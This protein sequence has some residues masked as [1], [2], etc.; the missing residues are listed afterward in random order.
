MHSVQYIVNRNLD[1]QTRVRLKELGPPRPELKITQ[2][3]KQSKN[4]TSFTRN[5]NRAMY[6]AADWLCGCEV[7]NAFF[8]FTCLIMKTNDIGWT[9]TGVTDLKNFHAK[10]KK[11][12][13][14][15]THINGGIE[16]AMLGKVDVRC[17]LD[18]AY[19][20]KIKT[21]NED[22]SKNRYILGKLID[23]I[24][25]C[26]KFELALRGH[27]EGEDSNNPGI[28]R[29]LVN[30]MSEL[31]GLLKQHIEKTENRA[32]VGLSKTVQNELLDSIYEVCLNL[33]R[34]E[35]LQTNYIAIEVDETT[36]CATLSQLG[37]I[38]RYELRGKLIERFVSFLQ[39]K[40]D[41]AKDVSDSIFCV[42]DKMKINETRE[43]LIAQSYDGPPIMSDPKDGVQVRVKTKYKN[44]HFVHCY[45]HQLNLIVERCVTGNKQVRIFFSTLEG[46]STFFSYSSKRT[47]VLDQVVKENIPTSPPPMRWN[48]KTWCVTTVHTYKKEIVECLD[49]IIADVSNDYKTVRK[50]V[51]LKG[52]LQD[53]DFLFWLHFFN[54]VMPLC[55]ILFSQLQERAVS[56]MKTQKY[57]SEFQS[58]IQRVRSLLEL[59]DHWKE[60]GGN[61]LPSKR[62]RITDTRKIA[63][64]EVCDII[65]MQMNDRFLF[66][67][68]L[69]A[70]LLLEPSLF[71]K[72]RIIFPESEFKIAVDVFKL[73]P[74][75]LR[76]EL[77][78][79]YNRRDFE[80]AAGA[81]ILLNCIHENNLVTILPETVRLLQII[82]TIPMPTGEA[83][84]CLSTLKR[85]KTFTQNTM[86]ED[87]LSALAMCSIE[88]QL[89]ASPNFNELVIDHF[90][91][92]KE[93]RADFIYKQINEV[94]SDG[95]TPESVISPLVPQNEEKNRKKRGL[96]LME[97]N[98]L[99]LNVN[100][101]SVE[102]CDLGYNHESDIRCEENECHISSPLLKF[103]VGKEPCNIVAVK[104][105]PIAEE[106]EEDGG[107]T[108]GSSFS[109]AMTT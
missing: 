41:T 105:E 53:D 5:F 63:A 108:K 87:R 45:A 83:E 11:H 2:V 66:S 80:K 12:K 95:I 56:S 55:N 32:F 35:I 14:S 92:Q 28:F 54:K 43:K 90:A 4:K 58:S 25:F 18:T 52:F 97:R 69:S 9:V 3:Q 107:L 109:V 61:G 13:Y 102:P 23:C 7:K 34:A 70:V 36:D 100:N 17:Q 27:G 39:P 86:K 93:R 106:L 46:F 22:V 49:R 6:N 101:V 85:V 103:E 10:V 77:N 57:I 44:A 33:I 1:V 67:D 75:E 104:E 94:L 42:L 24:K 68:H 84:R 88:N 62:A 29:G 73:N 82:V 37:F 76:H 15:E 8:C 51:G 96:S 98:M 26:G 47:A 71:S 40:A 20:L 72:H 65:T 38:M 21:F 16:F 31:D 89:L 50:A 79:L 48:F 30:L 59:D 19:R 74:V 99:Q 81:L 91:V 60:E 64:K 78:V